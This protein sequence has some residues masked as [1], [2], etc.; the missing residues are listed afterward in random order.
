M[1]EIVGWHAHIYFN[2]PETRETALRLRE[3]I[4]TGWPSAMMG[5]VHDR[6]VGPHPIPMYQVAFAPELFAT[7]APFIAVNRQGLTVLL[8]PDTLR[9]LDDH[10]K[11]PLW[12]GEILPLDTSMLPEISERALG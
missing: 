2:S 4:T 3:Q 11:N 12:M 1:S 8:H 9:P 5:R 6:P 10:T 7:L